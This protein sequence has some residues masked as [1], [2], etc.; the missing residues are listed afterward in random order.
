[1]SDNNQFAVYGA[2]SGKVGTKASVSKDGRWLWIS[3]GEWFR[4]YQIL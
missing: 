3:D 1:M 4:V 2:V